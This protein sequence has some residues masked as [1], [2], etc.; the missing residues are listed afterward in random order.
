MTDIAQ[1]ALDSAKSAHHRIDGMEQEIKDIRSL[2]AAVATV[3][4]KVDGLDSDVKEIKSDVKAITA[5]PGQKWDWLTKA[6]ITTLAGGLV[7][8]I[9]ALILK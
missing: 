5:Q 3:S 6:I 4:T 7:T 8:A 9:L 1:E 2:T